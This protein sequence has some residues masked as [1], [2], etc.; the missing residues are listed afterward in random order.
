MIKSEFIRI[1]KQEGA[2]LSCNDKDIATGVGVRSPRLIYALRINHKGYDV[3]I[4]N[5]TGTSFI[6]NITASFPVSKQS[7]DFDLTTKSHL[8]TLFSRTKERFK[9]ES[10]NANINTFIKNNAGLKQLNLL[11]K[12]TTFAPSISGKYSNDNYILKTHYHLQFSDWTQVIEP[13]I[14]FYRTFIDE[15]SK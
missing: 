6:A 2:K 4:V 15:F 13:F 10:N 12:D 9:L 11:A 8:S 14:Q 5:E 7:L 1:A 3:T